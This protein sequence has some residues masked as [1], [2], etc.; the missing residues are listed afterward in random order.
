MCRMCVYFFK[1]K[2]AYE[3]R[4]SDWSSDVCSADLFL[5]E[6]TETAPGAHVYLRTSRWSRLPTPILM[7]WAVDDAGKVA[8][9]FVRPKPG[10]KPEAAPSPY[11]DRTCVV[12]GKSGSVCV[13]HGGRRIIKKNK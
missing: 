8:G 13:D 1:P 12:E 4:I 3:M 10:A 9:F 6:S 5:A 7:Q 11:L 2:T